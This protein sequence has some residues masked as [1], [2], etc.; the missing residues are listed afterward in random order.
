[1]ERGKRVI[2]DL[3]DQIGK[4]MNRD[5]MKCGRAKKEGEKGNSLRGGG[6]GFLISEEEG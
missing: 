1:M 5:D 3:G 4:G 6:G 2:G